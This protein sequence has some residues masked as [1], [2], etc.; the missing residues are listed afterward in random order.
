MEVLE[1]RLLLAADVDLAVDGVT[2]AG[3]AEMHAT[4]PVG[5][6][7]RNSGGE[8]GTADWL[9]RIFLSSD[10]VLDANDQEL[11][12][13]SAR[14]QT[15]LV[16]EGTYTAQT[17]LVIPSTTPGAQF[18]LFVTDDDQRQEETD[19][20][21][22]VFAHPIT[23]TAPD[24]DLTVS[25]ASAPSSGIAGQ[26][27]LVSWTVQNQGTEA[28]AASWI[29]RIYLSTD[30]VLDESDPYI[31]GLSAA[32]FQQL[33]GG[34][35]Y[36][37]SATMRL[38]GE[39]VGD[40]FLLIVTDADQGQGETD[41]TNNVFSQAFHVDAP[42]LT[43]TV[44]TAPSTA[45]AGAQIP[46]TW[47]VQNTG[48]FVA[49][50]VWYDAV[51]F[52]QDA[53][54]DQQDGRLLN[55]YNGSISLQPGD[56][57]TRTQNASL[58]NAPIGDGFLL[59]VADADDFFTNSSNVQLETDESDNVLALPITISGPDLAITAALAP[60][61]GVTGGQIEVSW[62]VANQGPAATASQW[63]DVFYISSD[64]VLDDEDRQIESM[65]AGDRSP[66]AAGSVY[67]VTERIELDEAPSGEQFLLIHTDGI[68]RPGGNRRGEQYR[69]DSDH[70]HGAELDR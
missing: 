31:G 27:I 44:A 28:A 58:Y 13:R 61:T 42:N 30:Q 46:V 14:Y 62:T 18:L 5:W 60:A 34:D 50:A 16:S 3:T 63:Y 69:R 59:F 53:N 7:V 17:N 68:S 11:V 54:F 19:E 15:P 1:P 49:E 10:S 8:S 39:A 25:G 23:I 12:A 57:Y 56:S 66:L 45:V 29:D 9:D 64:E 52:S 51:Y 24:V 43:L 32:D 4:I 35:G 22:N 20:D 2:A 65:Y 70:D 26:Q 41:S 47:T 38:D 33:A 36:T 55:N 37:R 6:T 40:Q 48:T 21:N 67:T